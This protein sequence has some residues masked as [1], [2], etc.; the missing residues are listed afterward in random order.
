MV[1]NRLAKFK[2][3]VKYKKCKLFSE[4]VEFLGQTVLAAGIGIV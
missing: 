4:K 2:Y 1:F 3:H